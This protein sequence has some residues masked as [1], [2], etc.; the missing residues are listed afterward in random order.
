[1]VKKGT[2]KRRKGGEKGEGGKKKIPLSL[3][4]STLNLHPFCTKSKKRKEKRGKRKGKKR[5][6]EK[7]PSLKTTIQFRFTPPPLRRL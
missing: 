3:Y 4:P 2:E 7:S 1:M 6:R 5:G